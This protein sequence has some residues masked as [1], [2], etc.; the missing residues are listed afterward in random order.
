MKMGEIGD[1]SAWGNAGV[2]TVWPGLYRQRR[3]ATG[4][5]R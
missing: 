3:A 2:R 1:I 5:E 4:H